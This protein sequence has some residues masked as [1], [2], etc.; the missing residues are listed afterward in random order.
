MDN[1]KGL[2]DT[3]QICR[4]YNS[5][6]G[7]FSSKIGEIEGKSCVNCLNYKDGICNKKIY[8]KY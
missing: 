2:M 6:F 3:A 5:V 1:F 7:G 8:E 4:D